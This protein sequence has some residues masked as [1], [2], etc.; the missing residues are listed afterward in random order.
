MVDVW[1]GDAIIMAQKIASELGLG[2]GISSGA[3][4]IG[5]LETALRQGDD[6]VAVTVFA[7]CDKKYFSTDLC[8]EEECKEHYISRDLELFDFKVIPMAAAEAVT[9]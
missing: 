5:A 4:F 9:P 3:N 7:D 6:A 8:S 2:V 1:D